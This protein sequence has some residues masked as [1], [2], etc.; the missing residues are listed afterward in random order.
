M[1]WQDVKADSGRK[2]IARM[3]GRVR[4]R[5][6]ESIQ[7]KENMR[8]RQSNQCSIPA[9]SLFFLPAGHN[10]AAG[11]GSNQRTHMS[12]QMNLEV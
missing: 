5:K 6:K 7:E 3:D 1:F 10:T 4:E 8:D 2:S 11:K 9:H 12:L